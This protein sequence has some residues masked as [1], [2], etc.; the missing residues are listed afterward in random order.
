MNRREIALFELR[1]SRIRQGLSPEQ[2]GEKVG[3]D[4]KTI[5]RV[6]AGGVPTPSTAR[7]LAEYFHKDPLDIWP[8]LAEVRS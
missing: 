7:K 2:L 8:E 6:E 4:G 3:L 5:R 1:A